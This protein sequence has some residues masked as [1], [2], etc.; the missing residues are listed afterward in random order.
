MPQIQNELLGALLFE[1]LHLVRD[2]PHAAARQRHG[3]NQ[4]DRLGTLIGDEPRR[5]RRIDQIHPRHR[6]LLRLGFTHAQ[7]AEFQ[8]AAVVALHQHL[9][10]GERHIARRNIVDGFNHIAG[11]HPR[12]ACRRT[13]QR[14]HHRQ[15]SEPAREH[16]TDIGFRSL[17]RFQI[18][19]VLLGIQIA[20]VGIE[21]FQHAVD[22]AQCH[23]LH[24]GLFDIIGLDARKHFAV[25]A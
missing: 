22:R 7:N 17:L 5:N 6:D 3:L 1:L 15:I 2:F 14:I 25:N 16:Q 4:T 18:F 20:G 24:V 9:G 11:G 23:R 13:G 10:I 8:R 12:L 19:F 21:R